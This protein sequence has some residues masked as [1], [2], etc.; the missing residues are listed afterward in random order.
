VADPEILKMGGAKDNVSAL[1]SFI[2]NAYDELDAS[3]FTR[4][5]GDLQKNCKDQSIG[6][7]PPLYTSH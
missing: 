4:G 6:G 1:S 3:R 5:K 2:A 7:A